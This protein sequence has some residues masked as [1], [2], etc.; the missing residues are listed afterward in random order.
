M[1]GRISEQFGGY[2]YQHN[3][4]KQVSQEVLVFAIKSLLTNLLT[5]VLSL[6]AGYL[7]GALA[8]TLVVL[9][10]MALLRNLTGGYH[11]QSPTA[12]ILISSTVVAAIPHIPFSDAWF[13]PCA[14][15]AMLL[16]ILFA[17]SDLKGVT[18][19]SARRL[20]VMKLVALA[21]VGSNFFIES[22]LLALSFLAQVLTIIPFKGRD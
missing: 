21:I 8:D 20:L 6:T 3:D 1:I 16:I 13:I 10:A 5:I 14:A 11:F 17:P 7:L 4:R 9:I 18:T 2:I 15:V 22:H 12:C 19:L